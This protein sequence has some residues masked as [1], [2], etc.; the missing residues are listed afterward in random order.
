MSLWLEAYQ[1]DEVWVSDQ[2]VPQSE[3]V[4]VHGLLVMFELHVAVAKFSVQHWAGITFQ[5]LQ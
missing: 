3:T 2:D 1:D 4:L 5:V